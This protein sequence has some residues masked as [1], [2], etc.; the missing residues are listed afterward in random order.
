[1]KKGTHVYSSKDKKFGTISDELPDGRFEVNL[2]YN[3]EQELRQAKRQC[4]NVKR[5]KDDLIAV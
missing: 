4:H 2:Q 5:R 3:N 1:M